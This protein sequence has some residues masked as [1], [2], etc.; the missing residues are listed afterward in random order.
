MKSSSILAGAAIALAL[1]GF[2]SAF[3]IGGV[4]PLRSHAKTSACAMRRPNAAKKSFITC[5]Q[6]CQ[7]SVLGS[8]LLVFR[9]DPAH[10][11]FVSILSLFSRSYS[12]AELRN[13]VRQRQGEP[14]W[15]PRCS[16]NFSGSFHR[17][18]SVHST[19]CCLCF[20]TWIVHVTCLIVAPAD[21]FVFAKK[22]HA[23]R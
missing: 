5:K 8:R 6:N 11:P 1:P 10:I 7:T 17:A 2:S 3:T 13:R 23:N 22:I 4:A 12:R 19:S 20:R 14:A 15:P 16:V 18:A 21:K 9:M